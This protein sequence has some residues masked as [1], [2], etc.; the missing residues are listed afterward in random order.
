MGDPEELK[1]N[2]PQEFRNVDVG[3]GQ[4]QIAKNQATPTTILEKGLGPQKPEYIEQTGQ[5]FTPTAQGGTFEQ[6]QKPL[7]QQK[8]ELDL[9]A[10]SAAGKQEAADASAGIMRTIDDSLL[11]LLYNNEEIAFDKN[12]DLLAPKG[13]HVYTSDPY[14]KGKMWAM[15]KLGTPDEMG[16][17]TQSLRNIGAQLVLARGSLGAGV[18]KSDAEIYA[19]AAGDL[20][21]AKTIPEIVTHINTMR[22]I[23]RSSQKAAESSPLTPAAASASNRDALKAEYLALPPEV[24]KARRAEFVQKLGGM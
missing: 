7:M 19:K 5:V 4:A 3:Y 22:R 6:V 18:S 13:K 10:K 16:A 12:G 2:K 1:W 14:S 8:A 17:R 23:A 15:E 11:P 20:Q 24:R 9:Q 21:N